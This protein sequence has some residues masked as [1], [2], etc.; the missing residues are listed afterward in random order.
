MVAKKRSVKTNKEISVKIVDSSKKQTLTEELRTNPWILSTIVLIIL[1]ILLL[2]FGNYGL[3]G[4]S[5][6]SKEDAGTLLVDFFESRGIIGINVVSVEEKD[7]LY[8]VNLMYQGQTIP[9]YVTKSG[10]LTGSEVVS[11]VNTE[12]IIPISTTQE[13]PKK[14]KPEV[15]LFVMSYCPYGTQAEKGILPVVALLKDKVDFKIRFVHYVLH[16]EKEDLENKRQLCIREE[17][18]QNI[19]NKYL[20]CILNST[21]VQNPGDVTACEKTAGINSAQL[22]ACLN[23]K[24]DDYYDADSKLSEGYGVQGS[25]T[26][27]INGVM[28]EA[29]RNPAS[30][31]DEICESFNEAP[32]EC[33]EE[34]SSSVSS[35]GFGYNE[36][37]D[38]VAKC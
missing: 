35:T 25:P 32:E 26:L 30:Y 16:G 31:L 5:E 20:V 38:T 3:D 21:D 12:E 18:G 13:I 27:I 33:L 14:E 22:I 1:T 2:S 9:F 37:T 10:Y 6:I 23:D 11:L 4:K 24:A 15:E 29:G 36:G 28:S 17:Q 7:D 19:L 8:K 34:L